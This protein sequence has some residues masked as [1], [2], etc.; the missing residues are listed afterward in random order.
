MKDNITTGSR[1]PSTTSIPRAR[2]MSTSTSLRPDHVPSNT[3]ASAAAGT[4][5]KE[6]DSDDATSASTAAKNRDLGSETKINVFVRC[7]GRSEREVQEKSDVVVHTDGLKGTTVGVGSN[8]MSGKTYAFDGVFSPRADQQ[9]VFDEVVKPVLDEVLNGFNCTIFAYGQTG[10]GKTY[11]MSGDMSDHVLLPDDAGIILR[12]LHS[13]FRNLGSLDGLATSDGNESSVKISFIELYNEE[14]RDLLSSEEKSKLKIFDGDSRRG[15]ATVMQGM[16]ERYITCAKTGLDLLRS[17]CDKR[18]V[19]ATKCNDLSS[20]SHTVF[21]ITVYTKR[22]SASGEE[23]LSLGKLNLVDLA[24]S[25]NIGRSGAESKRAAEAGLINKSLLTLGRVINALVDHSP[26]IPYRESKLTRLLQ[27]SLGGRTKTCIIA[28]L[29][30]ARSSLEETISTLDYA[31]R[32]KN[33]KNKPQTNKLIPKKT[34]LRE[35]TEEIEK[36]KLELTATRQRNGVYLPQDAY[37]ELIRESESHKTLVKE[38]R[39][40]IETAQCKLTRKGQ[41][42]LELTSYCKSLKKE[43]EA[44]QSILEETKSSLEEAKEAL[45]LTKEQLNDETLVCREFE[46]TEQQLV[47]LHQ[48]LVATLDQSTSDIT[49]LHSALERHSESRTRHQAHYSRVQIDVAETTKLVDGR[50]AG[51]QAEQQGLI[52][53]LSKQMSEFVERELTELNKRKLDLKEGVT[54]FEQ[55]HQEGAAQS[56]EAKNELNQALRKMDPLTEELKRKAEMGFH[57]MSQI[58]ERLVDSLTAGMETFYS[59]MCSNY[60]SLNADLKTIFDS[61]LQEAAE[62]RE[63]LERLQSEMTQANQQLDKNQSNSIDALTVLMDRE[64]AIREQETKDMMQRIQSLVEANVQQQ[65]LRMG[66]ITGISEQLK[67]EGQTH[68]SAGASFAQGCGQLVARLTSYGD[69]LTTAHE[70]TDKLINADCEMA[71]KHMV[72]ARIMRSTT[73][74]KTKEVAMGYGQS[75][76]SDVD[77]LVAGIDQIKEKTE[78]LHST[79]EQHVY[80]L[81]ATIQSLSSKLDHDLADSIIR[82]EAYAH[83]ATEQMTDLRESFH[84]TNKYAHA[85]ALILELGDRVGYSRLEDFGHTGRTPERKDYTFPRTMPRTTSRDRLLGRL[86]AGGAVDQPACDTMGKKPAKTPVFVDTHGQLEKLDP[87][88]AIT[89]TVSLRERDPRKVNIMSLKGIPENAGPEKPAPEPIKSLKRPA[90]SALP[91]GRTFT[92]RRVLRSG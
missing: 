56:L 9:M 86:K 51:F 47:N 62:Q 87:T 15:H 34:L 89:P 12:V 65:Q 46:R 53:I 4:K 28:T 74:E 40:Q 81:N 50:L 26:H 19:A 25:E 37:E 83:N 71:E 82:N 31:F 23:V 57:N 90:S 70:K 63:E 92:K 44:T 17:G 54:I 3:D 91:E 6:R 10:T 32:A 18:Q 73:R 42:L 5:R 68:A 55:S 75:L 41:D 16:E 43:S 36:L 60:T 13:L 11:T 49:E 59:Q 66:E 1:P 88:V 78:S 24:G 80:N 30:P 33:I 27:D 8:G 2:Q 21:T 38:Q 85:R 64:K 77:N 48:Q 7:R 61:L 29:S 67:V 72:E 14:L 35:F 20:R 58:F 84:Y 39:E 22:I 69:N 79:R 52:D 45:E 76:V